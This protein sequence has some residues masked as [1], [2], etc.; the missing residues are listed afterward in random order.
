MKALSEKPDAGRILIGMIYL[1][2]PLPSNTE[3][4]HASHYPSPR[5]KKKRKEKERPKPLTPSKP[6]TREANELHS[7]GTIP[8]ALNI[9]V[10]SEP[11][12]YAIS[13]DEFSE[14]FGFARPPPDAE[15]VFYCKAGV[16]SR[17]AAGLARQAGWR[18][19]GEYSGSWLDWVAKGGKI[20][21]A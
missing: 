21:R 18:S 11:D 13:D 7:T 20:E 4:P 15:L 6:D 14:R 12:A 17:A 16:R 3:Q 1:S 19:V 5:R 10:V 2:H 9:P 8:G